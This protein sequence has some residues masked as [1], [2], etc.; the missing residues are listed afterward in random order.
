MLSLTYNNYT[1]PHVLRDKNQYMDEH[2][3]F[4]HSVQN[5]GKKLNANPSFWALL[6]RSVECFIPSYKINQNSESIKSRLNI[7]KLIQREVMWN[8]LN[9]RK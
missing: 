2:I 6:S 9:D 8:K 7:D 3:N 1:V 4:S 5:L